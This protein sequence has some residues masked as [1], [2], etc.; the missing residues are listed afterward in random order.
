[1]AR[2]KE[3][4][5]QVSGQWLVTNTSDKPIVLVT[6]RIDGQNAENTIVAV[7]GTRGGFSSRYF[8]P[9]HQIRTVTMNFAFFPAIASGNEPLV[10][11]LIFT[12]NFEDEHR[13]R[14]A[15]FRSVHR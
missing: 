15:K 2:G 13:V 11:D 8:I 10:V 3:P 9:A 6:A 14:G 7:E 5:T 4:G 12:A 1:M